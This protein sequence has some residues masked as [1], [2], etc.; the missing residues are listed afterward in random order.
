MEISSEIIFSFFGSTIALPAY[1]KQLFSALLLGL[2][3]GAERE[4]RNKVASLRTFAFISTGSCLFALLSLS[5][6]NGSTTGP[7]DVT[8]VAAGIVTGIGFLGGG[9]IFKTSD[10]IEGITTGAMIWITAALGM[11]CGF[12][13]IDLAVW[14]FACFVMI[15]FLSY[16]FYH[17]IQAIKKDDEPEY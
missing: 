13:N 1:T 10:R 7:Y 12:G 8:R 6:A 11:A 2:L 3:V 17:L 5:A 15:H 14:G 9:V 4:W 16:A